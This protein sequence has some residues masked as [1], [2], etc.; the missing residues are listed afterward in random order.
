MK[1]NICT[2]TRNQTQQSGFTLIELIIVIV[3]LGI[4]SASALPKFMDLS[5]EARKASIE[6][7]AGSLRSASAMA[8]AKAVISKQNGPQG[9]ITVEGDAIAL[10]H[11]YPSASDLTGLIA[12]MSG[13]DVQ[14]EGSTVSIHNGASTP[15]KCRVDYT[16][17]TSAAS[18]NIV[19]ITQDCR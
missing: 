17:A 14:V 1:K 15:A 3:I 19:L 11:G 7:M 6:G 2:M 10:V 9:T 12:D 16:Q 18:P 8:H 4:L 5:Q 13:Y